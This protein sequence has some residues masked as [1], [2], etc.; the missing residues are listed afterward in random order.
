MKTYRTV[1]LIMLLFLALAATAQAGTP[2]AAADSALPQAGTAK[3]SPARLIAKAF[4]K[5]DLEAEDVRRMRGSDYGLASR[6]PRGTSAVRFVIPSLCDDD[7][8]P[9]DSGGRIFV[10]K[11]WSDL[12]QLK[13]YYDGFGNRYGDLLFSWTFTNRRRNVL[14]QINGELTPRR[15]RPYKRI[16]SR[17]R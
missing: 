15:A 13:A 16:V 2:Q 11:R 17:L 14:V 4:R 7:E 12:L 1:G 6:P 10:F 9:C 8:D 3:R 5:A